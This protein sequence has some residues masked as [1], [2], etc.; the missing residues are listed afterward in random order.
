VWL[1]T[2]TECDDIFQ[3][4][5]GR[6]FGRRQIAPR[7][8]PGKTWEGFLL[9]GLTAVGIGVALAPLITP[10]WEACR[11]RIGDREVLVPGAGAVIA[12]LILWVTGFFG[13]LNMSALKRDA[14]VKD[15]GNWI[16]NQGGILDRMDS[17][18]FTAPVFYYLVRY[19]D[20]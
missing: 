17:L 1:I 16:P 5:W 8:S 15:T 2:F 4:L 13:D 18:L 14:G 7:I 20:G 9:G 19:I 3:A 6:R 11:F 10:L 12:G